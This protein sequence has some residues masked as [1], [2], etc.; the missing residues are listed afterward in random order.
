MTQ[1]YDGTYSSQDNFTGK[2]YYVSMISKK[3]T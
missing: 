2:L 3:L 1:Y